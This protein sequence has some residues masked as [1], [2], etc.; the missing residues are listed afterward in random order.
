MTQKRALSHQVYTRDCD[1]LSDMSFSDC[2]IASS[3]ALSLFI[4]FFLVGGFDIGSLL[5][6]LEELSRGAGEDGDDPEILSPS[7][8]ITLQ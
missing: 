7:T 6:D 2:M 3:T 4:F 8:L 5:D 1:R